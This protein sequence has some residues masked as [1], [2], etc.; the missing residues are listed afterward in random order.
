[1][2][3]SDQL[4][5]GRYGRALFEAAAAKGEDVRIEAQ[6]AAALKALSDP[7]VSAALRSPRLS[8]SDKK[9]RIAEACASIIPGGAGARPDPLMLR[10]FGLLVDK[11]R[12]E[13]LPLMTAAFGRLA[14]EKRR[15][16]RARV[17]TARPLSAAEADTL[18]RRLEAFSGRRVELDV[19]ED[20]DLIGGAVVR[21]GDWV[22]DGSLKGQLARLGQA[23]GSERG[24]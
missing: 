22:I 14:G 15:E 21:L 18:K 3:P 23:L 2:K 9:R 7:A 20:A 11:K 13:L 12:L 5:A 4:L 24:G 8:S 19:R 10:F 6:L 16:A 17:R 1:M